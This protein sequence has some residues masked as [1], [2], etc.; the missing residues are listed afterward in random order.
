[1]IGLSDVYPKFLYPDVIRGFHCDKP[2]NAYTDQKFGTKS[3][4]ESKNVG[5]FAQEK[6]P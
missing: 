3:C 5:Q 4:W 2:L 6:L 1:M